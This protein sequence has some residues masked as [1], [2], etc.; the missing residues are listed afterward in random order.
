MASQR[1][2]H[3]GGGGHITGAAAWLGTGQPTPV[4]LERVGCFPRVG[5]DE[6][7]VP[8]FLAIPLQ[9]LEKA[10]STPPCFC[11]LFALSFCL[12]IF[13]DMHLPQLAVNA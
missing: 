5:S 1:D 6:A 8:A 10:E 12:L 11:S 4:T 7:T 13:P 9:S 2:K 3:T